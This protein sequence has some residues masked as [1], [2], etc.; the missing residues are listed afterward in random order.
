MFIDADLKY[1]DLKY[2]PEIKITED[3]FNKITQDK[4][5]IEKYKRM[6]LYGSKNYF[7][8]NMLLRKIYAKKIAEKN[9]AED[10]VRTMFLDGKVEYND[11]KYVPELKITKEDYDSII[12]D[13]KTLE[14][15]RG[16]SLYGSGNFEIATKYLRKI[17][18]EKEKEYKTQVTSI[19]DVLEKNPVTT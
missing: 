12:N 13:K 15:H 1:D 3:K 17:T 2:V 9:T 8:A 19:L 14:M 11:L 18:S 5:N 7:D 4:E 6:S 10:I 16:L